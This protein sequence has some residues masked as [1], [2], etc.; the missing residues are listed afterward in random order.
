M[1]AIFGDGLFELYMTLDGA[2]EEYDEVDSPDSNF[3][4]DAVKML[5]KRLGHLDN[6]AQ[7]AIETALMDN[8][9]V[10]TFL[11]S[12]RP[13]EVP[14]KHQFELGDTNP[15]YHSAERMAPLHE[16]V[17]RKELDKILEAG[18]TKPSSSAWSLSVVITSKKMVIC[19]SVLITV[20]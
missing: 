6:E 5:H 14:I 15:I 16:E 11:D 3:I 2:M 18:I 20:H 1:V 9:I 17:V 8:S 7:C 4:S 12:L 10:A 13:V 19:A